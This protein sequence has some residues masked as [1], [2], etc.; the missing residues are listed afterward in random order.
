MS[1]KY[2][3]N[4]KIDSYVGKL[5]KSGIVQSF[6]PNAICKAFRMSLTSVLKRLDRLVDDEILEL[7]YEIR[8]HEGSDIVNI[9]D[10]YS[11]Y[12]NRE[13]YC[14]HCS[15]YVYIDLS[16]I[17]PIYFIK[18]DYKNYLKKKKKTSKLT[19]KRSLTNAARV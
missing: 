18:E 8:C 14:E 1:N 10:D 13:V 17:I 5:A 2:E 7:K 16:N 9:V 11:K 6:Y 19:R 12:I 3:L 15:D 4:E